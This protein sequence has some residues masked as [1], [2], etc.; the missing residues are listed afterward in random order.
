MSPSSW[1]P[2][3][4]ENGCADLLLDKIAVPNWSFVINSSSPGPTL[5]WERCQR[6]PPVPV[7]YNLSASFRHCRRA[8]PDCSTAG[9]SDPRDLGVK[10]WPEHP[11]STFT[12]R[13]HIKSR[14]LTHVFVRKCQASWDIL[15]STDFI[16]YRNKPRPQENEEERLKRHVSNSF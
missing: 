3:E 14:A 7:T 11:E 13:P 9:T 5:N 16:A 8:D 12:G 2:D 10:I 4:L 15:E 6:G 1:R